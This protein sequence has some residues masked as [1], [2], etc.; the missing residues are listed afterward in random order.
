M[1]RKRTTASQNHSGSSIDRRTRLSKRSMP[2]AAMNRPTLVAPGWRG[3]HAASV[4]SAPPSAAA[5]DPGRCHIGLARFARS[6][7]QELAQGAHEK[8]DVPAAGGVAH[9]PDPPDAPGEVA[10]APADLDAVTVEELPTGGAVV[11][12]L[13]Q[14]S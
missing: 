4:T 6:P 14:P 10:H 9:A 13:G 3:N 2:W 11:D 1:P 5:G 12:S 7:R 8:R